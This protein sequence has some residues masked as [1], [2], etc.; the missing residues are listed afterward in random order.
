MVFYQEKPIWS[1]LVIPT[2]IFASRFIYKPTL[3]GF[4]L[5]WYAWKFVAVNTQPWDYNP[6]ASQLSRIL[7]LCTIGHPIGGI[8]WF[9]NHCRERAL[10][11]ASV[12]YEAAIWSAIY[13]HEI[14]CIGWFL[15]FASSNYSARKMK[16]GLFAMPINLG[17][18]TEHVSS[19]VLAKVS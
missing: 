13:A 3:S 5:K 9:G 11:V 16:S 8:V 2:I 14:N 10:M 18:K 6:W 19:E 7:T 12:R 17:H 4:T 15:D 1:L